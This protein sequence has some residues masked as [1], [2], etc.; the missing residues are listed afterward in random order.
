MMASKPLTPR[1]ND[2]GSTI[3]TDPSVSGENA[4]CILIAL[5]IAM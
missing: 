1:Q 5:K 3:N 4:Y 2:A